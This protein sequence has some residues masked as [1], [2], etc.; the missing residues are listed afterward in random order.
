VDISTLAR[1][2]EAPMQRT[3]S[4]E[5]AFTQFA[6]GVTKRTPSYGTASRPGKAVIVAATQNLRAPL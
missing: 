4:A 1:R 3:A 5:E 2:T 6:S